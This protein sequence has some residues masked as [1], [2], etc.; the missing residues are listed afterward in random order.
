MTKI[1]RS[2]LDLYSGTRPRV[3]EEEEDAW[4]RS[5]TDDDADLGEPRAAGTR[6][7]SDQ[8][9]EDGAG[10]GNRQAIDYFE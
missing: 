10:V 3:E 1:E 6:Q 5:A 4:I 8:A 2:K 7:S 9:D